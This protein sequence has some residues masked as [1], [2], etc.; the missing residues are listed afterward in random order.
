MTTGL[1]EWWMQTLNL[2]IKLS[3]PGIEEVREEVQQW[4]RTVTCKTQKKT[5]PKDYLMKVQEIISKRVWAVF[6]IY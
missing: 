6:K 5:I 1:M 2:W 3:S 4:V